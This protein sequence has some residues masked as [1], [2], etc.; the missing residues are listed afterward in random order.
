ME[1]V[2]FTGLFGAAGQAIK[3]L[4]NAKDA[5]RVSD[6]KILDFIKRKASPQG[7]QTKSAFLVSKEGDAL[8]AGDA[9]AAVNAVQNIS[10]YTA[11]MFPWRNRLFGDKATEQKDNKSII[12]VDDI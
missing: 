9:T 10:G 4:R 11:R 2:A 12:K 6:N 5:D 1:G 3:K 8:V 7:D